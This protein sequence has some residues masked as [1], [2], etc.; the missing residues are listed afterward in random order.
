MIVEKAF[1]TRKNLAVLNFAIDIDK[2]KNGISTFYAYVAVGAA[3]GAF[4]ENV[5][6]GLV[7][8][9][10]VSVDESSVGIT[11]IARDRR[12]EYVVTVRVLLEIK[13][14]GFV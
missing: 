9:G 1:A 6:A 12:I 14:D 8:I 3:V 11:L 10:T 2:F 4:E 5:R 7:G 13:M